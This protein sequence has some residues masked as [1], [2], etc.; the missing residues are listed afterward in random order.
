MCCFS[1]VAHCP[2]FVRGLPPT[3]FNKF[4]SGWQRYDKKKTLIALILKR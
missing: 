3:L 1:K 2:K 4:A